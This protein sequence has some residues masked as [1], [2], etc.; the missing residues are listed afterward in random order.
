MTDVA[1]LVVSY[2]SAHEVSGFVRSLA[3]GLEGGT[4]ATVRVIENGDDPAGAERIAAL[5]GVDEF[6]LADRNLGYGGGMNRIAERAGESTD[7][8]L[9]CNP[10]VRFTPRSITRLVEAADRHD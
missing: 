2:R 10:D 7:W 4:T 9:V 5:D 3:R 1:I 8:L 6:V